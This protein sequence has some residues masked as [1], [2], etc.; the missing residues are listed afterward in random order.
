MTKDELSVIAANVSA[1]SGEASSVFERRLAHLYGL[2]RAFDG[3]VLSDALRSEYVEFTG[4]LADAATQSPASGCYGKLFSRSDRITLCSFICENLGRRP[5]P[6]SILELL[7]CDGTEGENEAPNRISYVHNYYSDEAYGTF[8]QALENP[9]VMYSPDFA[10]VCED[11]YYGRAKYCILPVES[12]T[13]GV[14][15]RFRTLIGKYELN[16]ALSCDVQTQGDDIY[17]RFALLRRGI[18]SL[19]VSDGERV[20]EFS[21]TFDDGGASLGDVLDAADAYGL[22]L[23]HISPL[24]ASYSGRSGMYD[25][26]FSF[27]DSGL[28]EFVV[29]LSLEVPQFEALGIYTHIGARE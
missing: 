11:V 13:D 29:F 23:R 14:L 22:K 27:A 26:A 21:A 3:G 9:T 16:I 24:P 4:S 7:G 12:S 2:A 17:T 19:P 5:A 18:V 8:A 6:P 25:L 28:P 15:S 1:L 10:S 20:F